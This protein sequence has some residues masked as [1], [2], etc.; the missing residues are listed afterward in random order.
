MFRKGINLDDQKR[1]SQK[2][3]TIEKQ[4]ALHTCNTAN[5]YQT[6]LPFYATQTID[7]FTNS[8][9]SAYHEKV[10]KFYQKVKSLHPLLF[11]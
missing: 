9:I 5:V 2:K 11:L 10:E 4:T 3:F 7:P 1:L 6:P 8:I